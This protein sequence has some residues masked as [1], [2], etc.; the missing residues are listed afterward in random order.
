[1]GVTIVSIS[2]GNTGDLP[3][4]W[5]CPHTFM[6]CFPQRHGALCSHVYFQALWSC[7][8]R[9]WSVTK[10]REM[11]TTSRAISKHTSSQPFT[12]PVPP[13]LPFA[14]PQA[15]TAS[16]G[17][18]RRGHFFPLPSSFVPPALVQWTDGLLGSRLALC[19]GTQKAQGSGPGKS[20]TLRTVPH[21]EWPFGPI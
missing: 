2:P 4:G 20:T 7:Q 19:L 10:Q 21:R 15:L 5:S 17:G 6:S 11:F 1:M 18:A 14:L 12:S 8:P 16:L 13:A 9:F 3:V